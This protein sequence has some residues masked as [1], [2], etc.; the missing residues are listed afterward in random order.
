MSD[1]V[2]F[3]VDGGLARITIDNPPLNVLDLVVREDLMSCFES[4]ETSKDARVLVLRGAGRR[5]FSVGSN[6]KQFPFDRGSEGGR[7]KVVF[8]QKLHDLLERLPQVTIAMLEGHVLGGGA[9][10]MMPCDLRIASE[11]ATFGFPEVKIGGFPCAGG[12]QRLM[13]LV[14]PTQA[15]DL[16]LFGDSISATRAQEL[17]LITRAVPDDHLETALDEMVTKLLHLPWGSLKA[18]K[19]CLN[20][21]KISWQAGSEAEVEQFTRI[22]TTHDMREGIQAFL[23]KRAPEFRHS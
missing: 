16:L 11:S 2:V 8:E 6:V 3:T 21:G 15:A 22:F 1:K 4:L 20:A 9:E 10:L 18:I 23:E 17:G 7:D 14:G 19:A 5:A 13:R 12:T